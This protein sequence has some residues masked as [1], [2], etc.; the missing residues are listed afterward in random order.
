[1][2]DISEILGGVIVWFVWFD[3]LSKVLFEVLR[4]D[5]I[6][7]GL[8]DYKIVDVIKDMF[9]VDSKEFKDIDIYDFMYYFLMV[10]RELNENNF[11]LK[12]L[13]E[14]VKDM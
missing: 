7:K 14:V 12:R 10:N 5:N 1:M 9:N 3:D 11:I 4:S 6:K 8:K 2:S 13:I